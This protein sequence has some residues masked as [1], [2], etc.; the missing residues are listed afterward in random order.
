MASQVGT[1][2]KAIFHGCLCLQGSAYKTIASSVVFAYI[3]KDIF[4]IT[5]RING[6]PAQMLKRNGYVEKG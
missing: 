5:N 1:I 6:Q 4:M 3:H 2:R